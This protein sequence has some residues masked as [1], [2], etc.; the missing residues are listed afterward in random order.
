[1]TRPANLRV[2]LAAWN[3]A[4]EHARNAYADHLTRIDQWCGC[5]RRKGNGPICIH[6]RINARKE[7]AE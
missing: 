7:T 1:M 2:L 6:C 5:G 4:Q 3:T